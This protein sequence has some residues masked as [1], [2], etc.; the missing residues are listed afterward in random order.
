M[1]LIVITD[2]TFPDLSWER[3]FFD[4]HGHTL[5]VGQCRGPSEVAA[6]AHDA[7]ALLNDR[8]PLTRDAV[9][10]LR[11]CRVIV[12]YGVGIDNVDLEA[13]TERGIIVC[14]VPDYGV[15]E[16]AT[17][18]VAL[19]LC[20]WRKVH[21]GDAALKRGEWISHTA[22]A[23]IPRT[24]GRTVGLFGFGR[25]AKRVAELLYPF[26]FRLIA[27]DP[28][29]SD[30]EM[31]LHGTEKVD[32]ETLL[33]RSD[34]FSLHAPLTPETRGVFDR[35]AFRGMKKGIVFVN[36]ARG[37]IVDEEALLWA[38]D[39]GIVA[40]AGLDVFVDEPC[41]NLKLVRHPKV[42]ATPHLAWYSEEAMWE[43]R[44]KAAEQVVQALQGQR[45]LFALNWEQLYGKME[46]GH[47][48]NG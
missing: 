27:Y 12:R 5:V 40:A 36:T 28:Y 37:G 7:D 24:V 25:I 29:V 46:R 44:K 33:R 2:T 39:E 1:G 21:R 42:I 3:E 47:R 30:E 22:I 17:H 45:P 26:G 35:E 6:I 8:C 14:N 13:A 32:W 11:R 19:L 20:C 38:L 9:G 15:H 34:A 31:L 10:A 43:M 48:E 41:P 23:P 4:R 16:V 18:A